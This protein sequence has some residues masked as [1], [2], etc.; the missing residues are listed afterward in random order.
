MA[1]TPAVL[2]I[3]DDEAIATVIKYNLEKEGYKVVTMSDGNEALDHAK[4][5]KPDLVILDWLLPAAKAGI[6]ICK[7]L[8]DNPETSGIPIIMVSV[9][10]E[11]LDKVV[12][13]EYGA[14]DYI[15]KPFSP[16]EFLARVK[17][18][19]RRIRPVFTSQ[20]LTFHDILMDLAGYEVRRTGKSVQLSPIEF[21]ILQLLIESPNRVLSRENLIDK[22]WG[23][24]VDISERTI[25]VHITRLRKAL[26]DASPDGF[27]VIKTV[28]LAGNKLEAPAAVLAT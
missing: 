6:E 21:K 20:T 8:R 13:L 23:N 24:G 1:L 19:L 25:D 28:R 10:D 11:N 17:A 16:M 22:I 26:L 14:D 2:V 9:K 18:V 5:F 3:E 12:G 15:I 7:E 27:D 4:T